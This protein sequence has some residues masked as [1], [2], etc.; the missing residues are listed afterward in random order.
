MPCFLIYNPVKLPPSP[1]FTEL[2]QQFSYFPFRTRTVTSLFLLCDFRFF[3]R[4]LFYHSTL[5]AH[6]PQQLFI[7]TETTKKKIL[8]TESRNFHIWL[9]IRFMTR[10]TIASS[11]KCDS[12]ALNPSVEILT[13]ETFEFSQIFMRRRCMCGC[14]VCFKQPLNTTMAI[15]ENFLLLPLKL[16]S[17]VILTQA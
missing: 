6:D 5:T 17:Y 3:F 7:C 10:F 14:S 8:I 1:T 9:S 4:F 2:T 12:S 15:G 16:L 13:R 11:T